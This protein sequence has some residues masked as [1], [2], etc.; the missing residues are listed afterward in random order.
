MGVTIRHV[1]RYKG[2]LIKANPNDSRSWYVYCVGAKGCPVLYIGI[3]TDPAKR[4]EKHKVR[5]KE[6]PQPLSLREHPHAL[7]HVVARRLEI[8][9]HEKYPHA[10]TTTTAL[11]HLLARLR[12]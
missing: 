1:Q 11:E 9:L 5:F 4:F 12:Q 2:R 6:A 3:S 7:Q 8:D 10:R